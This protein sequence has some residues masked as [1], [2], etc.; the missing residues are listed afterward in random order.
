MVCALIFKI[1]SSVFV[2]LVGGNGKGSELAKGRQGS[3]IPGGLGYVS[4]P[5]HPRGGRQG[6]CTRPER[7]VLIWAP[8]AWVC[9]APGLASGSAAPN[10]QL[11]I[12]GP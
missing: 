5:A 2:F 12:C 3:V 6:S 4:V 7:G 8:A 10:G 9:P 11:I 1:F